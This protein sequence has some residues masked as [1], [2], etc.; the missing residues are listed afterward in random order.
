MLTRLEPQANQM[1]TGYTINF[2]VPLVGGVTYLILGRDDYKHLPPFTI[3]NLKIIGINIDGQLRNIVLSLIVAIF[4]IAWELIFC[5]VIS[6]S[7]VLLSFLAFEFKLFKYR[8]E[9]YYSIN[10][11]EDTD[12]TVRQM[13][14]R[15]RQLLRLFEHVNDI[16]A[17]ALGLQNFII[18]VSLCLFSFIVITVNNMGEAIP[19]TY[20]VIAFS[21]NAFL[22]GYLGD[23]VR[24]EG[25]NVFIALCQLPW[26]KL[27]PK[28]RRSLI[29]ILLQ[30]RKLFQIKYKGILKT[31]LETFMQI[32][33]QP[34]LDTQDLSE[35]EGLSS[36]YTTKFRFMN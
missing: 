3:I 33:V 29:M 32:N 27:N 28:N 31:N 11:L 12:G 25:E 13:V 35:R 7:W 24:T 1:L 30:S 5:G 23:K 8:I 26:Y 14:W 2:I 18:A 19:F 9:T 15:H 20:G 22:Y 4:A 21:I 10:L 6:F 34:F 36:N 17:L 16:V